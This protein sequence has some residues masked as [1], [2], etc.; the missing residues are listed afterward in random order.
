[1]NYQFKT[2]YGKKID[3][4]IE[5][6]KNYI[7]NKDIELLIGADSQNYENRITRYGIVIAMY[8]KG[9]GANVVCTRI[10]KDIEY[11]MQKRLLDEVWMSI[12]VAE[13]LKENGLPKPKFIDIDLNPDPR[14]K[15]NKVL[16]QAVGLVEGMGYQARIKGHGASAQCAANHLVRI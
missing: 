9:K 3:N 13:Y 5:Y 2:L 15:S 7:S 12:E 4:I 11:N 8:T 10:D 16:R 14:Y 1:M 6:V